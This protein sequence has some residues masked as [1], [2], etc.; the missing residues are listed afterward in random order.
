MADRCLLTQQS[1]FPIRYNISVLEDE[2]L[3]LIPKIGF[4]M[5]LLDDPSLL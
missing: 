3:K 4:Y 5:R 2:L 1:V